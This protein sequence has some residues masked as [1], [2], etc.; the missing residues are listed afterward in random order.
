MLFGV[1]QLD[2]PTYLSV[3][4]GLLIVVGAACIV[5]ATR[6]TRVDPLTSMRA[7]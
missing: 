7:E 2:V 4:I 5:P 6:A 1:T 3:M